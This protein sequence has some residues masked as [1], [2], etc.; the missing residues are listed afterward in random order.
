MPTDAERRRTAFETLRA[1][2]QMIAQAAYLLRQRSTQEAYAGWR[3]KEVAY[4]VAALFDTLERG[5]RNLDPHV[6]GELVAAARQLVSTFQ[7]EHDAYLAHRPPAPKTVT[8][9]QT[10][11]DPQRQ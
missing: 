11:S 8:H 10:P 3:H 4:A 5:V 1:D 7:P 6:R 2:Q 9:K